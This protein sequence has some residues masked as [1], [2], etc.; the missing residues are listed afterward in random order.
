MLRDKVK[1]SWKEAK[2]K[3]P[4]SKTEGWAPK[5]ILGFNVR[6]TRPDRDEIQKHLVVKEVAAL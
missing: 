1:A 2:S 6:A 5:F 3:A 4:P